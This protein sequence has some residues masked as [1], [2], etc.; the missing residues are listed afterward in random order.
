MIE[1]GREMSFEDERERIFKRTGMGKGRRF[2][3]EKKKKIFMT[4]TPWRW[5]RDRAGDAGDAHPA[6]RHNRANMRLTWAQHAP[7]INI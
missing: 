7:N 4:L 6:C 2:F 1:K 3:F 5:G